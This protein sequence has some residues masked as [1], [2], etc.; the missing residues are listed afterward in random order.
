MGGPATRFPRQDEEPGGTVHN[1]RVTRGR[2]RIYLGAAPGVGKTY[3][4]L[5]EAHRRLERGTDVVVGFVETHDR[6]HTADMIVGL[7]VVPRRVLDHRGARFEEMDLDAVRPGTR[8]SSSSTSWRT[9]T[10]RAPAT[11]SGGRTST[12]SSTRAS[13]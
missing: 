11:P 13:T 9:P 3:A 5:A 8:R 2:L 4:M 6:R 7:E 1:G 10:S 12:S